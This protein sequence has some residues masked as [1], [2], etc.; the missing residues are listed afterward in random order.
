MSDQEDQQGPIWTSD[1]PAAPVGVGAP[2]DPTA[3]PAPIVIAPPTAVAPVV[4]TTKQGVSFSAM[5]LIAAGAALIGGVVVWMFAG[6]PEL[7]GARENPSKEKWGP[8][9]RWVHVPPRKK[10]RTKRTRK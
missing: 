3:S 5:I 2:G 8:G 10:K 4:V 7:T 1:P 6:Q 9:D